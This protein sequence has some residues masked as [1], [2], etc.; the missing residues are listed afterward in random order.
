MRNIFSVIKSIGGNEDFSTIILQTLDDESK[1]LELKN[2][3]IKT[4]ESYIKNFKSSI[5]NDYIIHIFKSLSKKLVKDS[6]RMQT[7]KLLIEIKNE[8]WS[9]NFNVSLNF[10]LENRRNPSSK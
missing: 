5:S 10:H 7:K 2:E 8:D 6:T 9:S 3:V 4:T 1:D